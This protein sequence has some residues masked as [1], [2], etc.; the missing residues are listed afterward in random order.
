MKNDMRIGD[1]LSIIEEAD[2]RGAVEAPRKVESSTFI[3][4]ESRGVSMGIIIKR[5]IPTIRDSRMVIY[6]T[7]H[8]LFLFAL[9]VYICV[10]CAYSL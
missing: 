4:V 10:V 8:I 7:N 6:F 9:F 1:D 2:F 3:I 5:N